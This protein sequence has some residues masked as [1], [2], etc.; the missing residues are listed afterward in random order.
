MNKSLISNLSSVGKAALVVALAVLAA[1]QL[2]YPLGFDQGVYAACGDIIRRGGVPIQDCFETKQPGVMVMYAIP[3]LFSLAPMAIHAFTL[4]WTAL[5]AVVIGQ[6][7]RRLF[8]A[9]SAWP[10]AIFYWLAYAGINYWSMDQ[11]ETFA[12]LFLV[13]ALFAVWR[14]GEGRDWRL[15]IGDWK[16]EI[17]GEKQEAGGKRS[18]VG[19]QRS[20]DREEML[21]A[22]G[23]KPEVGGKRSEVRGQRSKARDQKLEARGQKTEDRSQKSEVR[24]GVTDLQSPVPNPQSPI[25]NPQS[26][27]SNLQSL[28][29]NL[30]SLISNLQSNSF[31]WLAVGGAC[32]GVAFW[33]KY[34]F[35][36][37]AMALALC[38]LLHDWLRTRSWLTALRDSI[39][40][41]VIA[42]A[43]AG[44][45]LLYF[46]LNNALPAL[47]S[48][49]QFLLAAFPLGPPRTL[50]EI[51]GEL[52]RF[53]NNGADV[54]GD[55]KATVPQWIV[56]GGGFPL[57]LILAVIG[58]WQRIKQA[59]IL[60]AYLVAH[61]VAAAAIVVW[62]AN[63]IQ[64]H[65]TI[66][67]PAF[68][69]AASAP[70]FRWRPR[71]RL[72][73]IP[74][75]LVIAA[76]VLL[77]VRMLPWV[78]DMVQNVALLHKSPRDIYLESRVAPNVPVAEYI[79]AHTGPNDTI[80]I[81]GDAPWVY[82]LSGRR[83]ATRFSFIN[84][85]LRKR[86]AVTYPLF[87]GQ[88]LAGLERNQPIYFILTKADFPWPN[89]DYIPD[90]K[91]SGAIYNYVE[92]HYAYEGENGPFLLFRRKP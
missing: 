38:L 65:Y 51:A 70:D 67:I 31:F 86:Q 68:V 45:G 83:N 88:Y 61:F 4:L 77:S 8:G 63:Y 14:A 71:L 15:E 79:A 19:S 89:N 7:A 84:L 6:I 18:E 28:V 39:V 78:D 44:L 1:P 49:F 57:L 54:T 82:T 75:A 91:A 59:P 25:P 22:R 92:S 41:G 5:T 40:F 46:A 32:I 16:T 34:V 47:V 81:F 48:Q 64:Y 90:Y 20:E 74:A 80:A 73:F 26:L 56:L 72:T 42:L 76:V 36:L 50:P 58:A 11:A 27:I 21:E 33:F 9:R 24:S 12:N 17:G 62:Q 2:W 60:Y 35:A 23:E 52:A 10:A 30:Q 66:M 87:T 13:V 37:I 29:S 53:F 43:V 3:M 69:L 55:F 85:W